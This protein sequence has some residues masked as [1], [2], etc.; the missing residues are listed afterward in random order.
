MGSASAGDSRSG[1]TGA[2]PQGAPEAAETTAQA[3]RLHW[4]EMVGGRTLG[5]HSDLER[6]DKYREGALTV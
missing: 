3:E 4:G 2:C 6:E 1:K 5:G